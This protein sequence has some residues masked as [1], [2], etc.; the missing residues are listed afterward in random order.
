MVSLLMVIL[1][2]LLQP[3]LEVL[4]VMNPGVGKRFS[5]VITIQTAPGANPSSCKMGIK[6]VGHDNDHPPPFMSEDKNG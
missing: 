2:L 1:I 4:D 5:L 3:Y 6:W